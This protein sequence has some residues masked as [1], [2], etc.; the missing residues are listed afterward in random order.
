M[1]LSQWFAL[2]AMGFILTLVWGFGQP[3]ENVYVSGGLSF[4]VW[5]VCVLTAPGLEV[6]SNGTRLAAD[7][8]VLSFVALSFAALSALAVIGY[9]TGHYPPEPAAKDPIP[10]DD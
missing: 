6:V 8:A 4:I 1:L 3:D 10:Y 5:G 9:R 2:A 7:S